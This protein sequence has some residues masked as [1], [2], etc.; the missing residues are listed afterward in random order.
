MGWHHRYTP[1]D[2]I[3]RPAMVVKRDTGIHV[4]LSLVSVCKRRRGLVGGSVT[5][6]SD[7]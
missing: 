2:V 5:A 4:D 1:T 7:Y 6:A 3:D